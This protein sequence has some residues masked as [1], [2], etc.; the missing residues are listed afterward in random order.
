[1]NYGKFLLTK[2]REEKGEQRSIDSTAAGRYFQHKDDTFLLQVRYASAEKM[3]V[4]LDY[5]AVSRQGAEIPTAGVNDRLDAQ[6]VAIQEKVTFLLEEFKLI[7]LDKQNKRAQL[8]SYP[9]YAEADARYYYEIMLDE[10]VKVHFQ[11][12]QYVIKD[13]RYEKITSQLTPETFERLVNIFT[14]ILD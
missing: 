5:L 2:L 8:R 3:G 13:K 9:P 10:G 1:M 7:E 4:M 6:A 12:Y 14:G 11:R